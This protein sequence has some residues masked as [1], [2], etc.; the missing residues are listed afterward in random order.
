MTK[1]I[2]S[3]FQNVLQGQRWDS[4]GTT[5]RQFRD[6]DE[7][8]FFTTW[9]YSCYKQES[10]SLGVFW[11]SWKQ[12]IRKLRLGFSF[13]PPDRVYALQKYSRQ[14]SLSTS[15]VYRVYT[16]TPLGGRGGG[17]RVYYH[18]T[19]FGQIWFPVTLD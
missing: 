7:T 18:F 4:S 14:E 13:S 16:P 8:V 6:N 17:G 12:I 3:F 1:I 15:S 19:Q 9:Q 2:G 10:I 5:M 11:P